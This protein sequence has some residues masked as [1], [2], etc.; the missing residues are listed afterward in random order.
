MSIDTETTRQVNTL[1][2]SLVSQTQINT[3]AM[4]VEYRVAIPIGTF[5]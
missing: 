5:H 3:Y 2:I 1:N 4:A